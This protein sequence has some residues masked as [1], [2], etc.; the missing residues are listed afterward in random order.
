MSD[1]DRDV[2]RLLDEYNAFIGRKA[3]EL[4]YW[5]WLCATALLHYVVYVHVGERWDEY[6]RARIRLRAAIRAARKRLDI[7]S[8]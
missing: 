4:S 5:E 7:R 3:R 6:R 8:K 1:M 2:R